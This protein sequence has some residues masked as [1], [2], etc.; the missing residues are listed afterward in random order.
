VKTKDGSIRT[1]TKGRIWLEFGGG[2]RM[3]EGERWTQNKFWGNLR[4]FMN[5][6]LYRKKH[7]WDVWDVLTYRELQRLVWL[8]RRRLKME[9]DEYEQKNWTGVHG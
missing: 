8:T 7:G 6:Y 5:R 1:F 9:Y 2:V 3:F 4:M